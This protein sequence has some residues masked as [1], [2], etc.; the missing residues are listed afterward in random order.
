MVKRLGRRPLTSVTGVRFPLGPLPVTRRGE[1]MRRGETRTANPVATS[2]EKLD[3]VVPSR[4]PSVVLCV[5]DLPGNC[6]SSRPERWKRLWGCGTEIRDH[7][8]T[9]DCP[10]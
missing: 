5:G 6:G 2:I 10:Y 1:A 4:Y 9:G 7:Q 3:T 8:V